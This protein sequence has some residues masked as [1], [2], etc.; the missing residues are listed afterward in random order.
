MEG[1]G[2]VYKRKEAKDMKKGNCEEKVKGKTE[3]Y[4]KICVR[5]IRDKG[6]DAT[7][8][9][10]ERVKRNKEE[11]KKNMCKRVKE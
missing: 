10:K 9:R 3:E 2:K 1:R 11:R 6:E 4:K 5:E 8:K 7:G